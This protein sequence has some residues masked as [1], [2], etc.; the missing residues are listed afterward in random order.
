MATKHISDVDVVAVVADLNATRMSGVSA[1][2][3]LALRT[4][5]PPKVCFR[6]LERAARRD[7][8]DYGVSLNYPW[9]A[10]KGLQL[11]AEAL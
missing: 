1:P 4:G 6:A 8:I 11:Q 10:P 2:E 5:Q 9:L 7:L 3:R